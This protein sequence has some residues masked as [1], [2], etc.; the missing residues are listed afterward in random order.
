MEQY[1][2]IYNGDEKSNYNPAENIFGYVNSKKE[3][4][5]WLKKEQKEAKTYNEITY[6]KNEFILVKIKKLN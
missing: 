2:I 1:I 5:D 6:S 3:F 4:N